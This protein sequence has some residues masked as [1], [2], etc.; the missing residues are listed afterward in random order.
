MQKQKL[1]TKMKRGAA[2][3][4]FRE[5]ELR[6]TLVPKMLWDAENGRMLAGSTFCL[7]AKLQA[8]WFEAVLWGGV[9]GKECGQAKNEKLCLLSQQKRDT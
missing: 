8:S 6:R 4:G 1:I 7:F 9:F 2:G 5:A 3:V